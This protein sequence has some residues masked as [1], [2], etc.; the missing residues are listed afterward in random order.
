M[1]RKIYFF[2]HLR[3]RLAFLLQRDQFSRTGQIF[4][5]RV[6]RIPSLPCLAVFSKPLVL[7][8]NFMMRSLMFLSLLV[9]SPIVKALPWICSSAQ[10]VVD[11]HRCWNTFPFIFFQLTT[12]HCRRQSCS[13]NSALLNSLFPS[14]LQV[15][16]FV[17]FN[18]FLLIAVQMDSSNFGLFSFLP[19]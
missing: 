5:Q 11:W 15:A 3:G 7:F 4:Y 8:F 14:P 10:T 2:L 1:L 6:L 19:S 17:I 13:I 9:P 18:V 12:G 16:T